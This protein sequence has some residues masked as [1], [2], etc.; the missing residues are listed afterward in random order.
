MTQTF[1]TV[2]EYVDSF[3]A[4]TKKMLETLRSAVRKIAPQAK[5]GFSYGVPAFNLNGNL[6]LYAGFKNHIGFY[7]QPS[8][9]KKFKNRLF[10]YETSEGT[11]RFPLDKPLPLDLIIEIVEFRIQ[12]NLK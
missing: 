12:E 6:V 3:P 10:E 7:P 8:A 11:I 4:K 5:E 2:D 1:T 9:I